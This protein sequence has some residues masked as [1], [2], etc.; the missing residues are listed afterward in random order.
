MSRITGPKARLCRKFGMNLFDS[1]KYDKALAKRNFPPGVHGKARFSKK[2]EFGKQLVEKQKIRIIYGIT[3]RVCG[4]YFAEAS[5]K[6]DE[7]GTAFLRLLESRLDN[8]AFRAGLARTRMGAR[9]LV[10][11]GHLKL[12]GR[13]VNIP[14]IQVKPGDHMA[15]REKSMTSPL[16]SEVGKGKKLIPAWI[17]VDPAKKAVEVVRLPENNELEQSVDIQAVIGFYSK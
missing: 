15:V 9:Q 4:N 11:H 5:R 8:V 12:N 3:E 1:P 7:T 13:R 2:S 10:S 17:K 16:F 6:K 14:S